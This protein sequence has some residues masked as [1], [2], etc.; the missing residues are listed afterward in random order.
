MH[1]D[2]EPARAASDRIFGGKTRKNPVLDPD[3][4]SMRPKSVA[5]ELAVVVVC[6]IFCQM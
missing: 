1:A 2:V 3:A 4:V 5:I 6:R